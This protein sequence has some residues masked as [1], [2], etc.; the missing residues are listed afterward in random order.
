MQ[1]AVRDVRATL[2]PEEDLSFAPFIAI[3]KDI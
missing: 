2:L 1:A 3:A